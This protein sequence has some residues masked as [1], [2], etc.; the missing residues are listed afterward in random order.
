MKVASHLSVTVFSVL[1][2]AHVGDALHISFWGSRV[3]P[4]GQIGGYSQAFNAPLNSPPEPQVGGAWHA[5]AEL[6][7]VVPLGQDGL[8]SHLLADEF[9]LVPVGH[10]G[11]A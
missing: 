3:E 9:R 6:L 1:P 7:N 5:C 4:V 10:A 11:G 8:A 2:A